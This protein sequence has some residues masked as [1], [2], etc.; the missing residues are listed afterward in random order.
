MASPPSP[1]DTKDVFLQHVF[2]DVKEV[3]IHYI[4][5]LWKWFKCCVQIQEAQC[6]ISTH[7]DLLTDNDRNA[8]L[9]C[10]HLDHILMHG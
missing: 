6:N 5:V 9:L 3:S 8:Q 1:S 4:V 7:M 10:D 2:T